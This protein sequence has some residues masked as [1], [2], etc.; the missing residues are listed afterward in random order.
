MKLRPPAEAD[1]STR[2]RSTAVTARVGTWLG[3]CFLIA[4]VT[5]LIS[6]YAQEP[7]QPIPFPTRP[8]WLYQVTQ[9]LHVVTGT[10]AVPLLLVK[11]WSVYPK[12]FAMPPRRLKALMIE[13]AERTIVAVLVATA[14]FQL[15]SG[16]QNISHWYTWPF[17]FRP[18]HYAAGWLVTGA[19][20]LHIATK[21]PL[22]RNAYSRPVDEPDD[23]E[24]DAEPELVGA[25]RLGR[26]GL[27]RAT[28]AATAVAV[29]ATAGTTVPFL[30]RVSVLGVRSGDGPQGI[31]INRSARAAGIGGSATSAAYRLEIV[32]GARTVS[33]TRD[34]ILALPQ[35]T[36]RLP[37]AC[38]E[39]WSATADWTGV[40]MR[41]LLDLVG[42][43]SGRDVRVVSLQRRGAFGATLLQANFAD[44]D[45]TLL[46]VALDGETLA[47]DHG[48]PVRLIAPNRP[49]VLQT[50]W[51]TRLEVQA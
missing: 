7:S 14:I 34:Q 4:F 19:L 43:T 46:A 5:G 35:R 17:S 13:V 12:L 30:R 29:L 51:V 9:G 37:I 16:L 18:V 32:D 23:V 41:D 39:G 26:R 6:H 15:V 42:A 33:L 31:P 11:L 8:V 20:L 47:I 22:I 2:L 49:G 3:V 21:L 36:E 44:D 24:D 25:G 48:Y 28:W 1:F 27:L 10:A 40:R 45:R 50:K 38:V